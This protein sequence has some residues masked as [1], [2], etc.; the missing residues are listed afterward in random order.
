MET[1]DENLRLSLKLATNKNPQFLSCCY[2][3][4]VGN[5][6]KVD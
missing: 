5:I 4:Y 2:K 1:V 6:D 3:T